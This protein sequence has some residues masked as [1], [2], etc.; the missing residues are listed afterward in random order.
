[1]GGGAI[2][3]QRIP[4]SRKAEFANI[5]I[6]NLEFSIYSQNGE[7]GI[8]DLL[9]QILRLDTAHS[10]FPKAFIEFGV[11]NY[12]ESNT[13]FLLKRRNWLGLV[14]DG[15]DKNIDFIKRDEIYWKHD[16]EAKRAFITR[17]N[18]NALIK[19]WLD[20]R[21]LDNVGLLSIDID[22]VDYFVWEA[23]RCVNPAIVVIEFNALFGG[24]ERV[25]VP[26]R[27]DFNRFKAHFSGLFFGSSLRALIALGEKK[28]FSFIGTD[29][30]GT[31][32]FFI[33]NCFG[34]IIARFKVFELGYYCK[35]HNAR[36]SRDEKGNL[37]FL[38]GNDREAIISHLQRQEV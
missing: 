1:M 37:T 14:M 19:E 12:T 31:N 27:A 8:L 23:I 16:L 5:D 7:D 35:I 15:N 10:P 26:Y 11:E 6:Q 2:Q 28:G 24:D 20:S 33:N 38:S 13:R 34:E 25:T 18:I 4:N 17:E 29:S 3:A 22:G 9:I 21:G 30:S 32:A 36:Q